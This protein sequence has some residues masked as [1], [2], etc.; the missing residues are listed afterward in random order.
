VQDDVLE[1]LE[2]AGELLDPSRCALELVGCPN[3]EHEVTVQD[4]DH[5]RRRHVFGEEL[6][7]LGLGA[8]V[9]GYKDVETLVTGNQTKAGR[10][11]LVIRA[12][13]TSGHE[14]RIWVK[15]DSE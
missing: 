6:G 5:F 9:A 7:V 15:D 12:V 1:V 11:W 10:F 13:K 4:R 2:T 3:V 14:K 8:A